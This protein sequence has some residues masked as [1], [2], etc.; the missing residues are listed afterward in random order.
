M[1]KLIYTHGHV[2]FHGYNGEHEQIIDECLAQNVWVIMPGSQKDTSLA[3]VELAE[4]YDE[5]VYSAV[6]IHPLHV[7]PQNIDQ[8]EI[9]FQTRGES[10]DY[11]YYKQLGQRKNCVAIG[12]CG[13]EY[14]RIIDQAK[15]TGIDID[16]IKRKQHE[17]YEQHIRLANDLNKPLITHCRPSKPDAADAYEAVEKILK[18]HPQTRGV[19]HCFLGSYETA[20]RFLALGF[21]LSFTGIITFKN[22]DQYLLEAVKKIPLE[23]ILIETDSPYLT[24]AP[25]RGKRN[26]PLYVEH[27][28][29]KIAELKN[30]PLEEVAEVTTKNARSL[31]GV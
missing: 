6:G 2:S 19:M 14:F 23:R 16:E 24:P 7:I 29:K 5:G 18:K 31:F 28:A 22:A 1:P 9:H 10:F 12:E 11:E 21:F 20:T 26:H 15:E 30:I 13:I 27:V 3:A 17:T 4:K 8:E 25:H